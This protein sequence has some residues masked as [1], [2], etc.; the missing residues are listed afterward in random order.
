LHGALAAGSGPVTMQ[1]PVR[2]EP[3]ICVVTDVD[4]R[5]VRFKNAHEETFVAVIQMRKAAY[6][7]D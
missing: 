7:N 2:R 5:P 3:A 4:I 1:D 6:S